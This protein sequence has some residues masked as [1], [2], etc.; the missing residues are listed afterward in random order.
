[1]ALL[2]LQHAEDRRK[3][4]ERQRGNLER[5]LKVGAWASLVRE[6]IIEGGGDDSDEEEK[7]KINGVH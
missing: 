7:G 4:A 5:G 3:V 1:M 6:G 2:D